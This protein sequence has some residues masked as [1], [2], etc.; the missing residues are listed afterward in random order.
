[1]NPITE[2]TV[3]M[4]THHCFDDALEYISDR[5]IADP[6]LA[7]S[8]RL[9]LV[10]AIA[11]APDGPK[12]GEPFAH[13]WVEEDGDTV[14]ASGLIDG[15]RIWFACARAEYHEHLRVQ[16]VTTYTIREAWEQNKASGHFGP[17]KDEYRALC[18]D[19][20]GVFQ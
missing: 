19:N 1:M 6:E 14:W 12:K 7:F 4:P 18:S 5:V 20:R 9:M 8:S 15:E 2:S 3:I 16:A 17:W 11:Q 13:A 10:H